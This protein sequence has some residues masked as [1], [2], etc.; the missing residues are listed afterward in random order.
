MGSQITK[1]PSICG[2]QYPGI[3]YQVDCGES[4]RVAMTWPSASAGGWRSLTMEVPKKLSLETELNGVSV[5]T[6]LKSAGEL[7]EDNDLE[8]FRQYEQ[9]LGDKLPGAVV[10]AY[11]RYAP[12]DLT[13]TG[14]A[15]ASRA[16]IEKY[17]DGYIPELETGK[18]EKASGK[19]RAVLVPV[20]SDPVAI[21]I[22]SGQDIMNHVGGFFNEATGNMPC[23]RGK[24]IVPLDVFPFNVSI[25]VNGRTISPNRSLSV[26]QPNCQPNR[27][28]YA[29]ERMEKEGCR[30][31]I[32]GKPVVAGLPMSVLYGNIVVNGF[33]PDR[34]CDRSLTD[35]EMMDVM[36]YFQCE[37]PRG[38]GREVALI[39]QNG[40]YDELRESLTHDSPNGPEVVVVRDN[41]ESLDDLM[42]QKVEVA[43]DS[44]LGDEMSVSNGE[45]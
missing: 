33:D 18:T 27:T 31:S 15:E 7:F 30:S 26:R 1:I 8:G 16:E 36:N 29:T 12:V 13:H 17:L 37:S 14:N 40:L 34:V 44:E 43:G 45:R 10:R 35:G 6:L 42:E 22:S 41:V 24:G 38:S 32:D 21:G 5:E 11:A 9:M 2:D 20:G 23:D 28:F 4:V 19:F 25:Y 39:V 3:G